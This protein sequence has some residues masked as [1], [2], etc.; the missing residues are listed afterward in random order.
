MTDSRNPVAVPARPDPRRGGQGAEVALAAGAPAGSASW[1]PAAQH[2]QLLLDLRR[3]QRRGFLL[4]LAAFVALPTLLTLVYI[5][6]F[7]SPRFEVTYQTYRAPDSLSAGLVQSVAGTSQSNTV[8]VGTILYEYIRSDAMLNRLDRALGVRRYYSRPEIDWLS[9]LGAHASRERSLDYFRWRVSASEGLGGYLTVDVTAFDPAYAHALAVA[10]VQACDEMVDAMTARARGDETRFAEAEV[11]RQEDRVRQARLAL[12]AFQNA[13]GD[14]DPQQAAGQIGAIVGSLEADLAAARAQ[15]A[16]STPYLSAASPLVVQMKSRIAS[17][18]QQLHREQ[19][20]LAT[21]GGGAPYSKVL[22]QYSSL[23]L[24]EEFAR[25]AY[26]SAQQGL[27]VARADA[28]RRQDYLIDF[29]PPNE[30]DKPARSFA[31]VYAGTVFLG[32]LLA[33]GVASLLAG[34]FRDQAGL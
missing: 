17:L 19:Q 33:L 22:A 4:R 3:S 12:A 23:Q 29:A 18:E 34:A 5:L 25:T 10:V 20:R 7:A 11:A 9:R 27:A 15:L 16:D 1:P 26:Q 32:S 21:S 30:P 13:N 24:E 2:A 8:D 14:L 6:A 28:A 31:A